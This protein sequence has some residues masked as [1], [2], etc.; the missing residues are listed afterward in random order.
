MGFPGGSDSKKSTCNAGRPGFDPMGQED[1][2]E[3]EMSMH[4]GIVAWRI[5][6]T[7]E[8]GGL[9]STGSQR[10]GHDWNTNTHTHTHTCE[11]KKATNDLVWIGIKLQMC[12]LF[13]MLSRFVIT[14][15]PRSKC[16]LILWLK[17]LSAVIL[18]SKKIK[19]VMVSIVSPIYLPW[20]DGTGCHDFHF[21][22][23]EF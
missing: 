16:L 21:F 13:H 8:P 18:E 9:Q 17:S 11:M 1:P 2:L 20:S 10:I 23:I 22:N 3:K 12:L 15:L 4:S 6:C 7:E 19:S 14:F 5:P